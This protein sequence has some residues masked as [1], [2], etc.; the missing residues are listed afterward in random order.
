[1]KRTRGTFVG[2]SRTCATC[3]RVRPMSEFVLSTDTRVYRC[4]RC[5]SAQQRQ[6]QR[7]QGPEYMD[8]K[9]ARERDRHREDPRVHLLYG[10]RKRA[11]ATGLPFDLTKEDIVVPDVC[12]ILGLPIAIKDGAGPAYGSP[13]LDRFVP[14]RGYVRGNVWVISH[15]ANALKRNASVEELE[16]LARGV[17]AFAVLQFR[18]SSH[19]WFTR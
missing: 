18:S 1:M 11:R 10:A 14:S 3:K 17:R 13:S 2:E 6:W 9:K 12:P 19:Q 16:R 5:R 4:R 15:R 8:R 7:S